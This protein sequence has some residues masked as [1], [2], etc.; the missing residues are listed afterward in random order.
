MIKIALVLHG[1]EKKVEIINA[2][3]WNEVTRKYHE[4]QAKN[5]NQLV[6]EQVYCDGKVIEI[7]AAYELI[8]QKA[9][10][11]PQTV[12]GAE[13]TCLRH[14]RHVYEDLEFALRSLERIGA[15][16]IDMGNTERADEVGFLIGST[17]SLMLKTRDNFPAAF[18][19]AAKNE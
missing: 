18:I 5:E 3:C 14:A 8:S 1:I 4:L 17:Q 7:Q 2:E 12:L 9:P 19:E 15:I 11:E 10:S 16:Q 6:I 13:Q